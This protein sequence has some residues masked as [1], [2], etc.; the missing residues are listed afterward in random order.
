VPALHGYG[1][2]AINQHISLTC[3]QSRFEG[4]S[5]RPREVAALERSSMSSRRRGVIRLKTC[6]GEIFSW[7]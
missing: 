6:R 5:D 7:G 2:T 3:N 1:S 4:E